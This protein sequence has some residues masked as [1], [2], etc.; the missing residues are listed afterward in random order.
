MCS[1]HHLTMR[2]IWVKFNEN[3]KKGS[4]EYGTDKK[5]KDNSI[6]LESM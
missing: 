5:F 1:V 3:H 4:G 6:D 2:N